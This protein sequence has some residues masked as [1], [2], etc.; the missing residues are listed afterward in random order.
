MDRR[1][2]SGFPDGRGSDHLDAVDVPQ[3][4]IHLIDVAA[5]EIRETLISPP[6]FAW[7]AA[8][9]PD[10]KLLA[11]GGHGRVLIWDLSRPRVPS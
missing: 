8:F 4:R 7:S 10:G 2:I 11:T 6:S 9:S 3:P 1:D 5:G